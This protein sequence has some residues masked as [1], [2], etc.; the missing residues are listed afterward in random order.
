M[1]LHLVRHP[2][3]TKTWQKRCYGQSDPRLSHEGKAMAAP[4]IVQLATLKPSIIIHSDMA[5]TRAIAEPLAHILGIGCFAEPLWRERNFGTWEGQSWNC[6]YR[7]TGNAM[8]GMIDDPEH[9]RP[10]G[11]ETTLEMAKRVR[12]AL[13]NLQT[14]GRIVIVTHGGPIA[15][16]L[17][18][19]AGMPLRKLASLIPITGSITTIS[20][21]VGGRQPIRCDC[22]GAR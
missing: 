21:G 2:P 3:V 6:I 8:D 14:V 18:M 10:G 22:A 12:K 4:L 5:R 20:L 1:I 13:A 9:F 11:G 7:A 15:C 16:A 17:A 19:H